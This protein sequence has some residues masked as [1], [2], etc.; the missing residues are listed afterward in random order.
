MIMILEMDDGRFRERCCCS[1]VARLDDL[2]L[3]IVLRMEKAIGIR[4]KLALDIYLS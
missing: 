2:H 1:R 3:E 4:R